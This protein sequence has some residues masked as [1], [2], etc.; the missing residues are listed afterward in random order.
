MYKLINKVI[1]NSTK[2]SIILGLLIFLGILYLYKKNKIIEGNAE[3]DKP[4]ITPQAGQALSNSINSQLNAAGVPT[5]A[6]A[7]MMSSLFADLNSVVSEE[8]TAMSNRKTAAEK[9]EDTTPVVN[10]VPSICTNQTFF[11]GTKFGDAFCKMYPD[12]N[13]LNTKCAILTADSCNSTD[14]CVWIN[15]TRCVAGNIDGPAFLDGV[16]TD[17]NYYSYKYNCYGQCSMAD[18]PCSDRSITVVPLDCVNKFLSD[19]NCAAS[20][21]SLDTTT[22]FSFPGFPQYDF[23]IGSGKIDMSNIPDMNWG[24]LQDIMTEVFDSSPDACTVGSGGVLSVSTKVGCDCSKCST[25]TGIA[26]SQFD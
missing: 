13:I 26:N 16:A 3:S 20:A 21:F 18:D 7:G 19:S 17:A 15:G 5:A 8:A 14:C 23:K 9:A 2:N 10:T 6:N 22:A 24:K 11:E 25:S 12:K 4:H 1:N